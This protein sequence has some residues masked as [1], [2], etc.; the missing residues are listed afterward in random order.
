VNEPQNTQ[1]HQATVQVHNTKVILTGSRPIASPQKHSD[2]MTVLKEHSFTCTWH[3]EVIVIDNL[4]M[5]VD[6]ILLGK[7]Y[8]VSNGS[9]QAGCSAAAWIIEGHDNCNR[10]SGMC[11]SPSNAEG[12]SL[13]RNELASIYAMLFTLKM[14]IPPT[15]K[16]SPLRLACNGKLVL[17]WLKWLWLTDLQEPHA[18]L[19]SDT[20]ALIKQSEVQVE[21]FHVKGH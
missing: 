9:F 15:S 11:L 6:D 2:K 20:Q 13:F 16:Q 7:G 8:V 12:H 4:S 14:L 18:D 10:L 17:A 19:L 1:L 5:L 21:L 3:W